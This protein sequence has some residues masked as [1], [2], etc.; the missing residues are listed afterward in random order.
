[1]NKRKILYIS[2]TRADYG[3]MKS[4][5]KAINSHPELKLE[6]VATGMHLMPE[7]GLTIDEIK[8]DGFIVHEIPATYED[9]TKE[10]MVKFIGQFIQLLIDA[11][12]QIRPDIILILGDRCEMLAG[13]IAGTYLTIPVAHL[14]GGEIT[15]TVDEFSRHAITKLAHIHL[16]ATKTSAERI[17]K[18]GEDPKRVHVVGAPSLD[19]VLNKRILSKDEICKRLSLNSDEKIFLVVQ[20]PVTMEVEIAEKQMKNTMD[21]IMELKEQSVIIYPNADA[22]GR[23]MITVIEGY[24]QYPYVHIYKNLS[25]ELYLSLMKN[26]DVLIGNSSSGIIEAPSFKLPVVNIGTRQEGRERANNVIDIGYNKKEIKRA[27]REALS[28]KFKEKLKR[29][30]SPYGDGKTGPRVADILVKIKIDKRLLQKRL[31]Y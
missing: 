11:I 6:I 7:F 24:T 22:G 1:M 25:Y 31:T 5:L 17:I 21:T 27:I 14:H 8:N 2:G 23:R 12:K 26:A 29:C 9:D 20:H 19:S 4:V 13:A 15:S 3:L 16:P 18:M 10:S 30:K 28:T